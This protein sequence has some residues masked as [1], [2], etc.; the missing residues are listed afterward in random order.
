MLSF[1]TS[2]GAG[3]ALPNRGDSM[4]S[5]PPLPLMLGGINRLS[6]CKSLPAAGPHASGSDTVPRGAHLSPCRSSRR[7]QR[8]PHPPLLCL[9]RVAAASLALSLV[10]L[11]NQPSP[12]RSRSPWLSQRRSPRRSQ[13]HCR[14]L[15]R[16]RSPC[17]MPWPRLTRPRARRRLHALAGAH[18]RRLSGRMLTSR[19]ISHGYLRR[20]RISREARWAWPRANAARSIQPPSLRLPLRVQ[21]TG[22]GG[23]ALALALGGMTERVARLWH[24]KFANGRH[25][26][27]YGMGPRPLPPPPRLV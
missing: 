3:R 10:A 12:S 16:R 21:A 9:P 7:R 4:P 15:S 24:S 2:S 8:S 27:R 23:A 18:S 26:P 5:T 19:I 22:T 1:H 25:L 20:L 13:R 6:S 11:P 14:S 17:P